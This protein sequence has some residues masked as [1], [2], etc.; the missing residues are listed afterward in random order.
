MNKNGIEK[1]EE[2]EWWDIKDPRTREYILIASYI[3]TWIVIFIFFLLTFV[4]IYYVLKY[5]WQHLS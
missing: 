2:I 3:C 4:F 1:I 5:L